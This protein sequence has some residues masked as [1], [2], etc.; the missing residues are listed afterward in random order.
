MYA[1]RVIPIARG[2]FKGELTF[3]SREHFPEGA[4]VSA[5]LRGRATPA[6]VVSTTDA[7]EEKTS[8]RRAGFALKKIATGHGTRLFSRAFVEAVRTSALWHAAHEGSVLATLTSSVILAAAGKLA[9]APAEG[10]GVREDAPP[11]ADLLVLQAEKEERV[12]T[13]RNLAREAFARG[14]SLMILA[15][16]VIEAET[17]AKE[18]ERGIE[19]RLVL[20]T[21]E[22][23]KKKLI[24][25][26]NRAAGG[27]E[28]LLIVGTA[29]A[30]SV[31]RADV[32]TV[33]V[34]RESA[35]S[36]RGI[37]RP[38]IDVRRA[39]EYLA[40]EKGA[41]FILADFPVRVETRYRVDAGE[42]E[43][44]A[45]AQSRPGGAA[46]VVVRDARGADAT[47]SAAPPGSG[48]R[49]FTTL[50]EETLC[51]IEEETRRGGRAVVFAAWRGIAPLT[52]CNDCGTPVTDLETETPMILH[53]TE[54]GNVFFSHRSGAILPAGTPCRLCGGW[55]LV[56]LG[57]GVERVAEELKKRFPALSIELFTAESASTHAKATKLAERFYHTTGAILVGT[58][59]MLPYLSEPVELGVVASVDSFLSLPAWRS[60]EHTLSILFYLRERAELS[61]IVETRKPDHLVMKT[62]A[63]GNPADFYRADIEERERYGYPPFATF[64]GLEWR[65]AKAAVEKYRLA[66]KEW[67]ADTD[68][69]GPLPALSEGKNIWSAR[70]VIR[71]PKGAWPDASLVERLRALPP[72]IA[73]TID[74][75]EIA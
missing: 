22:V 52:V 43:D 9:E 59:R 24:E 58:E 27:A 20:F 37:A 38:R 47:N 17:L 15:P 68:L 46:Q 73:V 29:F 10:F 30:L 32:D 71:V 6:L 67:F 75:D 60:H 40:R 25:N 28:P 21:S 8:I 4:I 35:R 56:T 51:A 3:F 54:N 53:K 39:A 42:M 23:S 13:Y 16:T 44:L 5:P 33:I 48:K 50:A 26:W 19:E 63:S 1:V 74:P 62:I 36:Y 64:V 69:V 2:A 49:V 72:G 14:A 41:R 31:P 57:I 18:L 12:R 34:E 65:G 45:R 55:N 11:R 70:G 7:R 66:V 61:F